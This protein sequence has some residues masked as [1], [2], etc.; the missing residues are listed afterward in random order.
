MI[1]LD[2]LIAQLQAHGTVTVDWRA[3]ADMHFPGRNSVA[4][5]R[6]WAAKRGLVLI[7]VQSGARDLAG[8]PE[9]ATFFRAAPRHS[10][11]QE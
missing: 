7:F 3:F 10:T 4:Q 1:L 9:K 11:E 8:Q 6:E 5:A 2:H